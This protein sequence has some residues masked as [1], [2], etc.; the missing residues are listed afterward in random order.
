MKG[1]VDGCEDK[2]SDLMQSSDMMERLVK[3]WL[4]NECIN[5]G[6]IDGPMIT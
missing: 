3:R 1:W 4:M 5:E 6:M 2:K